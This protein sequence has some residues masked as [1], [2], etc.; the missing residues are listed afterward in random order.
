VIPGS[1]RSVVADAK[2]LNPR[3]GGLEVH[4]LLSWPWALE[5]APPTALPRWEDHRRLYRPTSP[6]AGKRAAPPHGLPAGP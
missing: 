6:D 1:K 4:C 5:T 2:D 3:S